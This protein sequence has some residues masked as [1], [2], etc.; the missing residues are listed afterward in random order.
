[1]MTQETEKVRKQMQMVC[2][3][4]LVPR[5]HLLRLIDKAIDWTFIYDL[6]RDTYSDGM[7]RPSIDRLRLLRYRLFNTCMES[8]ACGRQSKRLK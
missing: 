7:G 5:N 4:D 1:M 6:V 8:K 2:I 3:D